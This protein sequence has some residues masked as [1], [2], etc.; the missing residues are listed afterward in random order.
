MTERAPTG[1]LSSG[2]TLFVCTTTFET[3]MLGIY[4]RIK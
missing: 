4:T 1:A 2:S 3:G